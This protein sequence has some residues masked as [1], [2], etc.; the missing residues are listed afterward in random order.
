VATSDGVSSVGLAGRKP[1]RVRVRMAFRAVMNMVLYGPPS[2]N[3][4][5]VICDAMEDVRVNGE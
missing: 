3:N 5:G 2:V 4:A 1:V